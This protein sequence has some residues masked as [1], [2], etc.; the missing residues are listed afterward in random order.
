MDG[1]ELLKRY[2]A[3][4]QEAQNLRDENRFLRF[5]RDGYR[6]EWWH[7]QER[8]NTLSERIEKLEAENRRLKQQVKELTEASRREERAG[9]A[10]PDWVKGSVKRRRRRPGRKVGHPA[11]LRP[12][13]ASIDV[14]QDVPLPK[15]RAGRASCPHCNACLLE[16]KRHERVVEDIVPAKVLVTCYHTA[17]GWCPGCRRRVESRAAE[18][19]PVANVPHGQLGINA[20][21]TAILLRVAHRLPF[22]QVARVLADLPGLSVSAGAVARQVQR[23]ARWLTDDYQ[24][25]LIELRA[26]PHVHA[27]ETG[28]RTDGRNGYLWVLTD[29]AR[30]L[31]HVNKSR[32]GEVIESL[33][34]R[35]FGGT[36]VSDFYS[37]YA[38]LDCAKQKCLAHLLRELAESCEK[39]AAFAAGAFCRDAKRLLKG[40]LRLKGR[41]HALNDAQYTSRA[42][43]LESRLDRL[44]AAGHGEANERRIAK[45]M[46][47]H[48]KELTAFLWDKD[49]DGTNN[50]AER[51]LRPAV[52]ARKISGGSRSDRGADAWAKLASLLRTASQQGRRLIDTIKTMLQAKWAAAP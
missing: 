44:L 48:R 51:A 21:A 31:Y 49:L 14:R 4:K 2:D 22:R 16:V 13:P 47:R 6:L 35:A 39:S 25:L 17:S 46:L 5:D 52:V 38:R 36:L 10:S 11:A 28:W 15:D 26:S 40:M 23:A 18:Q 45:R 12:V 43:A 37:A 27:D 41:W 42:C 7:A 24:K 19:P 3:Y 30:T 32:S 34:G 1:R 20:L 50:A 8:I 33:V 29:P 9:D